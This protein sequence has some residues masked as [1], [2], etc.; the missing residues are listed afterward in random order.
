MNSININ[1][2]VTISNTTLAKVAGT[3]LLL[4]IAYFLIK[5]ASGN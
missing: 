1:G 5:S 2:E 4:I 3:F